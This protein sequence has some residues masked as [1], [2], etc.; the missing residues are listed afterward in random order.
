MPEINPPSQNLPPP[1]LGSLAS[2]PPLILTPLLQLGTPRFLPPSRDH[3]LVSE[4]GLGPPAAAPHRRSWYVW[5]RSRFCCQDRGMWS[6]NRKAA[7]CC[8]VFRGGWLTGT[9]WPLTLWWVFT[10]VWVLMSH[11]LKPNHPKRLKR[12]S[13]SRKKP[14]QSSA[15]VLT[16]TCFGILSPVFLDEQAA[17]QVLTRRRRANSFF[18]EVKKGNYER[19]CVEERCNW[20]EAREIFEDKEKT[21][22]SYYAKSQRN[23][24]I[25]LNYFPFFPPHIRT[26]SGP[27]TSV[28]RYLCSSNLW[29]KKSW[30]VPEI[31]LIFLQ[32]VT[33]A[34]PTRVL[35]AGNAKTGLVAIPATARKD[36]KGSTV[37]LVQRSKFWVVL[38]IIFH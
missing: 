7:A 16:Q 22:Q 32:M 24:I 8:C 4:T 1:R 15:V 6:F 35:M 36:T 5:T 21:V 2:L 9:E 38:S 27:F 26:S 13:E 30:G 10:A 33:P 34:S 14:T 17:S 29:L 37:K 28:S 23:N 18:E 3:V 19:E 20:E 31:V 12:D 25:S 11:K